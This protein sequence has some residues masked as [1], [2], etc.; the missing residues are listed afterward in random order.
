MI[1]ML[2]IVKLKS[3][4]ATINEILICLQI[5]NFSWS[6][7]L[8]K[9][10]LTSLANLSTYNSHSSTDIIQKERGKINIL[11]IRK[12]IFFFK[13]KGRWEK[14][15]GYLTNMR[16][17]ISVKIHMS[18]ILK[19]CHKIFACYKTIIVAKLMFSVTEATDRSVSIF[20]KVITISQKLR[21]KKLTIK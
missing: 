1:M 18:A 3:P 8:R 15:K 7:W 11:H 20:C 13:G 6:S 4:K 12:V 2:F 17:H 9:I 19:M 5:E 21:I 16:I 14:E 10:I